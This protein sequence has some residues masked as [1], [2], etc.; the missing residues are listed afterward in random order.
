MPHS[1]NGNQ[2]GIYLPDGSFRSDASIKRRLAAQG[3]LPEFETPLPTERD[4]GYWSQRFRQRQEVYQEAAE[5]KQDHVTIGL[6]GSVACINFFGDLHVGS[7]DT[8]Y[9]RIEQEVEMIVNT[10]QSYAM[11]MGDLVDGMFFNP[12]QFLQMEQSPEQFNYTHALVEYLAAHNK[13]LVGWGGDHDNWAKKM[14]LSAYA[15]FAEVA[16]AHYMYG[17][18]YVTL[19]LGEHDYYLAGA[20]RL[21]GNSIYN[22]V[23]PAR[24]AMNEKARGADIVVH[25]HTHRKG[26]GTQSV[27]EFGGH[28]RN[29]H[30]I[31]IGP[32]KSKDDYARKLGFGPLGEADLYGSAIIITGDTSEKQV[33]Y[34]D[35]IINANLETA[36]IV[37]E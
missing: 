20:H 19:K 25:G 13:I 2:Q 14:G 24:R 37:G 28:S 18:G 21:P 4:F 31:S 16:K 36:R 1:E 35:S 9:A 11:L 29:A 22:N 17:L 15:K 32:Y 34:Y 30:Y 23:H 12:G 8:D 5:V 3:D 26:Y 10:P 33:L 6:P 7:P 27:A